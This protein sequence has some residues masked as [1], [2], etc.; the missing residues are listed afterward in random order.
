[1]WPCNACG[2]DNFP[3]RI[4]C[5][6]CRASRKTI[7]GRGG[8]SRPGHQRDDGR[9]G[10]HGPPLDRRA[11]NNVNSKVNSSQVTETGGLISGSEICEEKLASLTEGTD[12][13]PAHGH[14]NR[15]SVSAGCDGS[16]A[17]FIGSSGLSERSVN[18]CATCGGM[19]TPEKSLE[20][21]SPQSSRRRLCTTCRDES[22]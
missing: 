20:A 13:G 9:Q 1:M 4:H 11:F 22:R 3:D 19:L 14:R 10:E 17:V 2:F 5:L 18:L 6:R 16:R 7:N 12:G 8:V 21:D 15:G